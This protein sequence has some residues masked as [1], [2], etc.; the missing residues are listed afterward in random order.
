MTDV[1]LAWIP[2]FGTA[3]ACVAGVDLVAEDGLRTAVLLSLFTDRRVS[4]G[5]LP[6]GE[7]DRRGWWG[8]TLAENDEIG[9]KLWLLAREKETDDVLVRAE[10][11]AREAL[12]WLIA[13]GAAEAV[14]VAASWPRR[15]ELALKVDITLADGRAEEFQFSDALRGQ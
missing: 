10:G 14:S 7:A 13:D 15:G 11:Y 2:D 3:D 12:A 6:V 8:D 5:E 9:S 1:L 4:A